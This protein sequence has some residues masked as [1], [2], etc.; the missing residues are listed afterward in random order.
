[1]PRFSA[2]A[3]TCISVARRSSSSVA[4]AHASNPNSETASNSSRSNS[5]RINSFHFS[6]SER[7]ASC[8]FNLEPL[9]S[10][11]QNLIDTR[12]RLETHASR[13]KQTPGHRSNRYNSRA[14]TF[15]LAFNAADSC[16]R[17]AA[18]ATYRRSRQSAGST[19][20]Q[21]LFPGSDH[22][23]GSRRALLARCRDTNHLAIACLLEAARTRVL[24]SPFSA[25]LLLQTGARGH[26]ARGRGAAP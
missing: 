24:A 6:N 8:R 12:V 2:P 9:T 20:Y 21:S 13:R 17:G 26:R 23:P 4:R 18:P 14:T 5:P 1:M 19:S 16:C 10:N 3:T 25:L 22:E 7:I 11:F 15:S